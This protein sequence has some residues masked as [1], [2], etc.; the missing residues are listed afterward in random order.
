MV[1]DAV[2]QHLPDGDELGQIR[3]AAEMVNM[4]K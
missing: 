3:R 2:V 1:G 4:K